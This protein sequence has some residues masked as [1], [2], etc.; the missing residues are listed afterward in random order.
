[1]DQ[2][3]YKREMDRLRFTDG[4]KAALEQ[5]ILAQ[6][7][8]QAAPP[9]RRH[10]RRT[11]FTAAGLAAALVVGA[12]ATG[13]FKTVREA[14]DGVMGGTAETEIV[15]K[16]GRPIGASQTHDG[17]TI[18]ADAILGDRYSVCVVYTLTAEE[19]GLLDGLEE[20]DG[21]IP[22][23]AFQYT[24][25]N[26]GVMGG[27]HGSAWFHDP[28]EGDNSIQFVESWTSDTPLKPGRTATATFQDFQFSYPEE[29]RFE[30]VAEGKWEFRFDLNYE[31]LTRTFPV[32]DRSFEQ[33]GL[34]F[35]LDEVSVSP[36]SYMVRY[37]VDRD[38][39]PADDTPSGKEPAELTQASDLALSG[40]PITLTL[41]DGSALD[42]SN[43]GG[44][45]RSEDGVTRCERSGTF[46]ALI[47]PEGMVSLTVGDVVIPL[48]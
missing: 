12:A 7:K 27:A 34:T 26:L 24:D 3:E 4:Q 42:L 45:M 41:A 44:G 11:A 9:P 39:L 35:S 46:D 30:T 13:G 21:V 22:S 2:F 16:I 14:F 28:V 37:T 18:T 47:P 29:E 32:K 5:S 43:T 38:L 8:Q 25:L 19:P 6:A 20:I 33:S 31:N 23:P 40:V 36:F 10:M 15:D 1:M 17:L 48:N